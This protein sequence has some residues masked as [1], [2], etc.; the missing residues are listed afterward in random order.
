M[1]YCNE[2][3]KDKSKLND[4]KL[5]NLEE[6]DNRK[7]KLALE[8][9]ELTINCLK[10]SMV[11]YKSTVLVLLVYHHIYLLSYFTVITMFL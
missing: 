1:N 3:E 8:A 5:N 2:L 11:S 10:K 4:T 9:S 7:L 6:E